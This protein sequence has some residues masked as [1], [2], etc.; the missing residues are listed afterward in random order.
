VKLHQEDEPIVC[1]RFIREWMAEQ[2]FL[3][4][5]LILRDEPTANQKT[6]FDRLE[7][8][9]YPIYRNLKAFSAVPDH[10]IY[11]RISWK[12]I[13]KL[14]KERFFE[15]RYKD[16][17]LFDYLQELHQQGI[18]LL[19]IGIGESPPYHH[20]TPEYV[21]ILPP[22]V[23]TIQHGTQVYFRGHTNFCWYNRHTQFLKQ[24][25][26]L[27]GD[28]YLKP[29]H[30]PRQVLEALLFFLMLQYRAYLRQKNQNLENGVTIASYQVQAYNE[31]SRFCR[32]YQ[33]EPQQAFEFI[34]RNIEAFFSSQAFRMRPLDLGIDILIKLERLNDDNP[35]WPGNCTD[36]ILK[37]LQ[38]ELEK[39]LT[40]PYP[41]YF[42]NPLFAT[43]NWQ[44]EPEIIPELQELKEF[45]I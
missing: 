32:T 33:I 39:D 41:R 14:V 40:A 18:F 34:N 13:L 5:N 21:R 25:L 17:S 23:H 11:Q 9:L 16:P 45:L 44:L 2:A 4:I 7:E 6:V 8:K 19:G 35:D 10:E 20:I 28:A 42:E 36:I 22:I 38:K 24:I 43:C 15:P 31:K 12:L 37:E 30:I 1:P 26:I 3:H 29:N 27:H